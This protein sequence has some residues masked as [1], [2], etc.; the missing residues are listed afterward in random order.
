M[1]VVP[2]EFRG[3]ARRFRAEMLECDRAY[4][5]AINAVIAPL[6]ARLRRKPTLRREHVV[7]T[8]R[9]CQRLPFQQYRL[10]PVEVLSESED[11]LEL[12]ETRVAAGRLLNQEWE[13]PELGLAI[14]R[15]RLR[16]TDGMLSKTLEG[17]TIVSGHS[18]GRRFERVRAADRTADAVLADVGALTGRTD[19]V[20][21]WLGVD[22]MGDSYGTA[23]QMRDIRTWWWVD[24]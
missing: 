19:N 20:L 18:L 3:Q 21:G 14:T 8:I 17:S 5:R 13:S 24:A 12:V 1:G 22:F 11:E 15:V 2:A 23:R 9:G 6:K 4:D 16:V 7:D 10:R